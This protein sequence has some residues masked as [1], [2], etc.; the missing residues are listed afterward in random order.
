MLV[1]AWNCQGVGRPPR[2]RHLKEVLAT[3]HPSMVF[4][5]ETKNKSRKLE[6]IRRRIG[7]YGHRFYIDPMGLSGRL[8]LWWNDAVD[9]HIIKASPNIIHTHCKCQSLNMDW[10]S[11]FV[12]VD[13]RDDFRGESWEVLNNLAGKINSLW[14]VIEDLNIIRAP[15]D[16]EGGIIPNA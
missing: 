11:S 14:F 2:I 4:L 12:Y 15:K 10:F 8:A 16:K 5:V 13:C 7:R 6:S 1:Q 3:Y 9:V